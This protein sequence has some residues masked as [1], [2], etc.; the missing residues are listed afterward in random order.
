MLERLDDELAYLDQAAERAELTGAVPAAAGPGGPGG[1]GG[2]GGSG[3]SAG[4]G[5]TRAAHGDGGSSAAPAPDGEASDD[6]R[7]NVFVVYGRDGQAERAIFDFLRAIGLCPLEWE[8]VVAETGKMSP[9]LAESVRAGLAKAH[10]VV[11]LMTPDDVVR[12]H[13]ALHGENEPPAETEDSMQA[14]PNVLLEMG[15]AFM[16]HPNATLVLFA[17]RM[18]PV[19]DLGGINY[20]QIADTVACRQKIAARLQSAGCRVDLR[21]THWHTAGDFGG[22]AALRRRAPASS[23]GA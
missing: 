16:S 3:G 6:L 12:L 14:R 20:V 2:S 22:L 21:G 4:P 7:R 10:A 18:R 15:M 8:P 19:T 5:A 17:G 9:S 11:A 23:P 13:P 1:P